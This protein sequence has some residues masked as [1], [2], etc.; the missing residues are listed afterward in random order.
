MNER[1]DS[2]IWFLALTAALLWHVFLWQRLSLGVHDAAA[3]P[4]R[5]PARMNYIYQP[6]GIS[7]ADGDIL[8]PVLFSL[9]SSLGFSKSIASMG[10]ELEPALAGSADDLALLEQ[11][12]LGGGGSL[13]V[14]PRHMDRQAAALIDDPVLNQARRALAP[15]L[16]IATR[17]GAHIEM[18]GD[19]SAAEFSSREI[20][21][22]SEAATPRQLRL[23]L[24][25]DSLG[26]PRS[27]FVLESSGAADFDSQ[28]LMEVKRW[29][30]SPQDAP[31]AGEVFLQW[32]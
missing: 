12:A 15:S 19:I 29:R 13:L 16:E 2:L 25:F 30:I 27:V 11:S 1:A 4:Q 24:E 22:E 21:L 18:V 31:A 8:T 6:G 28:A 7:G 20:A 9:P 5:E 32:D 17:K 23:S 14:W 3:V 10:L 26:L